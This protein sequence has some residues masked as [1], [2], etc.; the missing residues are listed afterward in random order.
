[1]PFL[2]RDG[3]TFHY[4]DKGA[5][6][7]FVFQHGLGGDVGQPFGLFQPPPGCRFLAM[8]FRAH[9]ETRPLGDSGKLSIA[10]FADDVIA[11]MDTLS[12]P[13]AIVGGVS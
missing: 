10:C 2:E 4:R 5:G 6:L 11:L 3:I 8:D 13:R 9:G 1:M 12:L 7:P